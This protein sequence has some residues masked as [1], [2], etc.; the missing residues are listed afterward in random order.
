MRWFFESLPLAVVLAALWHLYIFI[1]GR[2]FEK[3]LLLDICTSSEELGETRLLF[4]EVKL[5]NNGKG[6]LGAKRVRPG[7]CVYTDEFEKL[8]YSCS[9]QIKRVNASDLKGETLLDWYNS[10]ELRWVPDVPREINLLDEYL[11]PNEGNRTDFWLEPGDIA[12][13]PASLVL[14]PG[15]YLLKVS[16][17]GTRLKKDFWSRQVH[18]FIA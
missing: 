17:Y 4:V 9:L 13:L 8:K 3:R 18:V 6:K 5:T 1:R 10:A 11:V 7:E 14:L 12:H 16:F 2:T 15:H